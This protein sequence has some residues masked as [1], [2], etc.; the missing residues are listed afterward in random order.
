MKLNPMYY[1]RLQM[2]SRRYDAIIRNVSTM[3]TARGNDHFELRFQSR[4]E[5]KVV[6]EL[7]ES[8][9]FNIE[10]ITRNSVIVKNDPEWLELRN[11]L[12]NYLKPELYKTAMAG[13][14][15]V[16][17]DEDKFSIVRSQPILEALGF[18]VEECGNNIWRVSF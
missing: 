3:A 14:D 12:F 18:K 5:L 4:M 11:Q 17:L 2:T 9:G 10:K 13:D 15:W 6:K 16:V 1:K 8:F 7:V